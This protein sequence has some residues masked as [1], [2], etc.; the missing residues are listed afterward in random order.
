MMTDFLQPLQNYYLH[1][2]TQRR[3][4]R[5]NDLSLLSQGWESDIYAFQVQ[6]DESGRL[7]QEDLVLRVYPGGDA[8]TKSAG[9]Y[10]A[11]TLLH[12]LGYPV[13]RVDCL[14]RD[15]SPLGMPFLIMERIHGQPLWRTM[16]R[17]PAERCQKLVAL[18]CGLLARL[19]AIDWRAAVENPGEY[20]PGDAHAIIDRV[21]DGWQRIIRAQPGLLPGFA[22][23][24]QWLLDHSRNVVSR[25]ASLSHLDFHPENILLRADDTAVVLDWT[26]FDISDYRF[27]LAWTLVLVCSV[28]GLHWR[29]PLVREY[30]RQR[31]QPVEGLEFFE[32]A[33]CLRRLY[34]VLFSLTVGAEQ[35]G[36]RPGAEE[37]MRRQAP[38]L[39]R[40]HELFTQ[41]TGMTIPEVSEFFGES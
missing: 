28:E 19:H 30:E 37:D 12:R 25:Q 18:F 26:N 31:G 9:E 24:F 6:W 2:F 29:E 32:A 21:L 11:L 39:R 1:R 22:M 17:A 38:C 40:V 10:Q 4:A 33:A 8:Y 20:E 36:M 23:P 13:P 27:D 41:R 14:E 7:K 34:S 15:A 35:L 5:I 3:A 16:F